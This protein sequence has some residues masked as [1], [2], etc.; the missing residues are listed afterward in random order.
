MKLKLDLAAAVLGMTFLTAPAFADHAGSSGSE[1]FD[2]ALELNNAVTFSTLRY[3]VKTTVYR[4]RDD[5]F[6]L[7]NCIT[8][9][10]RSAF[11]A[12]P[13]HTGAPA[14][15]RW[16][17]ERARASWYPVETLLNDTRFDYPSVYQAYLNARAELFE[18]L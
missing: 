3:S 2:R 6:A 9:S 13:D 5:A 12:D 8:T 4:F 1:L 18:V 15:C 11:D 16:Q 17:A 14:S 10:G 7:A